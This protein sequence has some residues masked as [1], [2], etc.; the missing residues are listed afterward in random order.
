MLPVK[1]ILLV[2]DDREIRELLGKFLS[3]NGYSITTAKNGKEMFKE[4]VSKD[5][6]LIILDLIF[7][8]EDGLFLCQKLKN[9]CSTP[10]LMLTAKAEE[11]ERIIGLEMGADDYVTKPFNPRELLARIKAIMR[12]SL[13]S[14]IGNI[15]LTVDIFHFSGWNLNRLNRQLISPDQVE[16]ILS[17]GEFSLLVAFLERPQRVL[18]RDQLLDITKN[19]MSG[20]YD[21]S[22]DIQIS[23]V[24]HKIEKDPKKPT[25][26]QTIRSGG[27]I[28]TSLVERQVNT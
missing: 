10:L 21:R 26:L 6:D 22:I 23:R 2:D 20:P 17:S 18:S 28:L 16:V 7:P 15:N 9:F 4:V 14:I 1:K 3:Q 27:Y 25:L 24:R 19:R 11:T 12:R 13:Q 5:F 8:E